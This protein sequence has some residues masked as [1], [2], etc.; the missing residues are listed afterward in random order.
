MRPH[1]QGGPVLGVEYHLTGP[2]GIGTA[3]PR[4]VVAP[5][6]HAHVNRQ[7]VQ[8]SLSR[9]PA[10]LGNVASVLAHSA[11]EF[12]CPPPA[13]PRH[14]QAG[15]RAIRPRQTR[16]HQ[17]R[18]RC[19]ARRRSGLLGIERADRHGRQFAAWPTSPIEGHG[20]GCDREGD[21]AGRPI[22]LAGE[23]D[24]ACPQG[25]RLRPLGPPIPRR[26]A[27]SQTPM[28][29]GA[30]ATRC[31]V[32]WLPAPH[33]HTPLR[34]LACSSGQVHHPGRRT[35][36]F[37]RTGA[38]L[39]FE[40]AVTRLLRHGFTLPLLGHRRFRPRPALQ[41]HHTSMDARGSTRH[42]GMQPIRFTRVARDGAQARLR[43]GRAVLQQ[44]GIVHQP[45]DRLRA[46]ALQRGVGLA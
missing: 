40:P 1:L 5:P 29:L 34:D 33:V 36:R 20:L 17:P 32:A 24:G 39:P 37:D 21:R 14:D 9:L 19:L 4:D 43:L 30:N 25:A 2:L 26:G 35:G 8:E 42:R 13:L 41:P 23:G 27:R 16:Q 44:R 6:G 22:R 3:R 31:P 12:P 46:E 15:P 28:L 11:K 10:P 7:G 38:V 45:H 18:H